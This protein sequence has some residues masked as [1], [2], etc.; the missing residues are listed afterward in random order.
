MITRS[1]ISALLLGVVLGMIF[2]WPALAAV[3][4]S[5]YY[6]VSVG[7]PIAQTYEKLVADF[8][9][10]HPDIRVKTVY[11]G[12]QVD[13]LIK[14][15][16][17]IRGGTPPAIALL[18]SVNVY[19][20]IDDDMLVPISNFLKDEDRN[21]LEDLFPAFLARS[22]VGGKIWTLAFKRSM[23][24]MYYN[25]NAFREVGLNPEKGPATWTELHEAALKLTKKDA[26]GA[27]VRYGIEIPS[28]QP[29]A[30]WP[31]QA[32]VTE[33]GGTMNSDDGTKTFF[34]SPE[35]QK[36]LE[37]W[38]KL[39][40]TGAMAKGILQWATT[41]SNFLAEK[42]A[43]MWH[44]TGNLVRVKNEAKFDVGVAM[45]PADVRRGAPIGGDDF[46]IFKAA[47]AEQKQAAWTFVKWMLSP[48]RTAEFSQKTGYIAVR[49][50]AYNTPE[51]TQYLKD[52]PSAA[53]AR[54][55]LAYAAPIFATHENPRVHKAI[56]DGIQA[57][58]TG[59]ATTPAALK[60]AQEEAER[61]LRPFRK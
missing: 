21:M 44:T 33:A 17:A 53:V 12:N 10:S 3:E 59:K 39:T 52:Y 6:S 18:D 31:L 2:A 26:A 61:I 25:K 57:A 43:I 15:Q 27:V 54:D 22:K 48:E 45:L 30:Y 16:T 34:D 8:N 14:V 4:I 1:R 35:H 50:A 9:K 7:G 49:K 37:F 55:Q 20:L 51:M 13:T 19:T 28:T 42:T 60:A 32:L 36:A 58:L 46:H 5:F 29:D 24:I 40:D 23:M 41:P 47:P 38:V 56:M 11:S